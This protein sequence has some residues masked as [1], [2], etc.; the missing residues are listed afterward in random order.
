MS[1]DLDLFIGTKSTA[2]QKSPSHIKTNSKKDS[3][4]ISVP[5][6]DFGYGHMTC[7]ILL[8]ENTFF[9]SA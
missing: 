3:R 4:S 9:D 2:T 8:E 1:K 5:Y 7:P 6:H